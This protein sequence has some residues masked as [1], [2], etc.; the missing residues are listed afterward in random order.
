MLRKHYS[1]HFCLS[2]AVLKKQ[3]SAKENLPL[4]L[5]L[6]DVGVPSSNLAGVHVFKA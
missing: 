1:R 3:A 2:F 5:G 4:I 6:L